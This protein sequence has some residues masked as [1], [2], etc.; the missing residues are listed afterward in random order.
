VVV[1]SPGDCLV[2][3]LGSVRPGPPWGLWGLWGP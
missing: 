3:P 2:Q 1:D